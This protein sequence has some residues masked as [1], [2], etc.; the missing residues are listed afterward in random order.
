MKNLMTAIS[1]FF[2]G[3]YSSFDPVLEA[4]YFWLILI[5]FLFLLLLFTGC[6]TSPLKLALMK[7]R[8][9]KRTVADLNTIKLNGGIMM[10][11]KMRRTMKQLSASCVKVNRLIQAYHFDNHEH[12]DVRE[13]SSYVGRIA[14]SV[15]ASSAIDKAAD[16]DKALRGLVR[17]I[18]KQSDEA[19]KFIEN[20]LM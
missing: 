14:N 18:D 7:L 13:L 19:I 16:H 11:T 6:F 9:I 4:L 15:K 12:M 1:R 8:K 20:K 2:E 5:G 10:S 3:Q 17:N